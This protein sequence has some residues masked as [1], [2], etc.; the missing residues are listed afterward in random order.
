V[1]VVGLGNVLV[2]TRFGPGDRRLRR[3][4]SANA[5]ADAERWA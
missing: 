1:R 3:V 5:V 2:A 4:I